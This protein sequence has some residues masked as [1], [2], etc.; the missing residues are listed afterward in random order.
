MT[1]QETETAAAIE[2]LHEVQSPH[3]VPGHRPGHPPGSGVILASVMRDGLLR[4]SE[5]AAL[6]WGDVELVGD[7]SGRIRTPGSKP[8][9]P[10]VPMRL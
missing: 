6:R 4:V 9:W 7:G 5:A 10:S 3:P 8:R 1:L 2:K